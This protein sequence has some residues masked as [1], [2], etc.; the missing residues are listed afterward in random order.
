L[1]CR[2]SIKKQASGEAWKQGGALLI[3]GQKNGEIWIAQADFQP[4][5]FKADRLLDR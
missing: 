1:R 2:Q 3:N 5:F 4:I